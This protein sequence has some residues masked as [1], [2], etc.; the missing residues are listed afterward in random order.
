LALDGYAD[1]LE[2]D[3]VP[4]DR[5]RGYAELARGRAA[6]HDRP[7]L[8]ELEEREKTGR[9]TRDARDSSTTAD[10]N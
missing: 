4:A 1:V 5:P 9:R 3:R 8:Q 2:G 7:A 10:K 6:F